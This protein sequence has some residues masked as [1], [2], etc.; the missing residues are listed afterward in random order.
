MQV[1][2]HDRALR[3]DG[4]QLASH[5]AYKNFGILGDSAVA[6]IG[7]C[8][9]R[10]DAMV[11]LEDVRSQAPIFSPEMLH[12]IVE[13]FQLELRGGVFLQRLLIA[14]IAELLGAK[15]ARD[16]R[17]EGDDLYDGEK[18]LSVSIATRSPV[19]TLLHL[20]LNIRTEGTPVPTQG[21]AQYSVDPA[22][23]AAECLEAF[24]KEYESSL[25]AACKV[26]GVP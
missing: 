13:T 22:G 3:Y 14:S 19:S 5:F 4:S 24:K 21:L 25:R 2:F 15:G 11:D 9:V 17:R 23:F 16:L 7:P 20:G 8:E 12:F 6:F 26:R 18:K 1:H 10:L